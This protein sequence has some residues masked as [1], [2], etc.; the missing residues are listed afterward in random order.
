MVRQITTAP[1]GT[2]EAKN[3]SGSTITIDIAMK[4]SNHAP[5]YG[6]ENDANSAGFREDAH[7]LRKNGIFVHNTTL[8][9]GSE[10]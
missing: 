7:D 9:V 5:N 4:D 2:M 10:Q 8:Q 3:N 6:Y 1:S